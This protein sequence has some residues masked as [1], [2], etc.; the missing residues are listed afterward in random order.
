MSRLIAAAVM[1][2][3]IIV[4][5]VRAR[6]RR[7]RIQAR[8]NFASNYLSDLRSYFESGGADEQ[9]YESLLLRANQ[10]QNQLGRQG[11][12]SNYKPPGSNNIFQNVAVILSLLP[13]LRTMLNDTWLR[14]R[15]VSVDMF[16]GVRDVLLLHL[17]SS[18]QRLKRANEELRS[19]ISIVRLGVEGILYSPVRL[20]QAFGVLSK[21]TSDRLESFRLVRLLTAVAAVVSF[22][23]GLVTIITGHQAVITAIK[24]AWE[25]ISH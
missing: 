14:E 24:S 9:M 17:G 25:S 16:A 15:P 5:L 22:A 8:H 3:I 11:F 10:M 12:L 23:S 13:Q 2:T 20:L 1:L 6:R 19:P 21:G 4:G 18:E 7:D